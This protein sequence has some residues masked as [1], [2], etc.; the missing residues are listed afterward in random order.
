MGHIES[1]LG[2]IFPNNAAR[3]ILD[4][5][6][7]PLRDITDRFSYV[8]SEFDLLAD[9]TPGKNSFLILTRDQDGS[10]NVFQGATSLNPRGISNLAFK[11]FPYNALDLETQ[12][13]NDF[14][15]NFLEKARLTD[16]LRSPQI[17]PLLEHT[18]QFN[19][20]SFES[21]TVAGKY[22]KKTS[23]NLR[24]AQSPETAK[25]VVRLMT[26]FRRS[27]SLPDHSVS[28]GEILYPYPPK[29]IAQQA[30][31]YRREY[32]RYCAFLALYEPYLQEIPKYY[33]SGNLPLPPYLEDLESRDDRLNSILDESGLELTR[34]FDWEFVEA[35]LQALKKAA[36][37]GI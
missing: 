18:V 10:F 35:N 24:M 8:V 34:R 12:F 6:L 1:L 27:V 11:I 3:E 33:T 22:M 4:G 5:L 7:P 26:D 21:M 23:I 15:L 13:Y 20:Y 31:E 9:N 2:M 28:N 32:D 29:A 25:R 37:L 19:T 36:R 17:T 14:A 16:Y 30:R